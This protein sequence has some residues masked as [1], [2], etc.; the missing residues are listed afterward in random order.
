MPTELWHGHP[1]PPPAATSA[2]EKEQPSPP[3]SAR[4]AGHHLVEKEPELSLHTSPSPGV[5]WACSS[6]QVV[7]WPELGG[8]GVMA[9]TNTA[10][11]LEGTG[12]SGLFRLRGSCSSASSRAV[13]CRRKRNAAVF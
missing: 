13:L 6:L 5:S 4:H 8:R 1:S 9:V 2:L 3:G 12:T 11:I 10:S 7:M